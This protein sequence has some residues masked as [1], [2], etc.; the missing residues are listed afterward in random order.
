M[1][2]D[3]LNALPDHPVRAGATQEYLKKEYRGTSIVKAIRV[4]ALVDIHINYYRVDGYILKLEA[5][6]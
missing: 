2:D 1:S 3:I 4:C 6:M 5:A